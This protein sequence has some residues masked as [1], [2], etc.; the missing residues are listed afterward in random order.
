MNYDAFNYFDGEGTIVKT[1]VRNWRNFDPVVD[2]V[3]PVLVSDDDPD[4][5]FVP[6]MVLSMAEIL[7]RHKRGVQLPG[8]GSFF[9]EQL[10]SFDGMDK[11]DIID[12][13][14]ANAKTISDFQSG[15]T[16]AKAKKAAEKSAADAAEFAR[17]KALE[18]TLGSQKSDNASH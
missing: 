13:A 17:L 9:D 6:G 5:T 15:V 3:P 12:A 14:R 11:M 7:S 18:A 2:S 16:A 4:H 1:R 8:N 10:P